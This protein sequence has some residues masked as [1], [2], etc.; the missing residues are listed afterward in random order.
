VTWPGVS[1]II[2]VRNELHFIERSLGAMRVQDYEGPIEFIL[3]DGESDD[4]TRTLTSP[5]WTTPSATPP[6]P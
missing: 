1:V 3:V 5:C 2:P 6:P 4:G